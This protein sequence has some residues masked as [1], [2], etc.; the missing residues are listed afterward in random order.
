[1]KPILYCIVTVSAAL[2]VQLG[3]LVTFWLH[4]FA[5]VHARNLQTGFQ[6][7]FCLVFTRETRDNEGTLLQAKEIVK[8]IGIIWNL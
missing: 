3:D 7:V 8:Y 5:I 6:N 1:M 4:F 2:C